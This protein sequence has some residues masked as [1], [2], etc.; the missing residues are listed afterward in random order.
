MSTSL[1]LLTGAI[2]SLLN[3]QQAAPPHY[4]PDLDTTWQ[5]QLQG[6]INSG[7]TAD[8]YVLDLFD[9][10]QNVID[11]LH[12]SGRRVICYFSAGTFEN[13]REDKG[14]FTAADKG[15]RLGNWPGERWLDTRS[16]NVRAIMSDRIALAASMFNSSIFI[17]F[18]V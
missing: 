6:P 15:R 13:W 8:L 10:P 2:S 11:D 17:G 12:A 1:G 4:Q 16:I 5:I 7:Y 3:P 9:T 18:T 14:R